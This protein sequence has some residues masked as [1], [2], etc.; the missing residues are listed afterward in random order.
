MDNNDILKMYGHITAGVPKN[1]SKYVTDNESSNHWDAISK[2]VGEIK[3]N[4]QSLD[5]PHDIP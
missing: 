2:Q 5:M 4:G 3:N 1:Q